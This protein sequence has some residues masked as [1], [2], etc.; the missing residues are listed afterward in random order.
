MD[1]IQCLNC[2]TSGGATFGVWNGEDA[3]VMTDDY[4][5]ITGLAS[6]EWQWDEM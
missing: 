1:H 6:G 5:N 4:G 3:I 2:N